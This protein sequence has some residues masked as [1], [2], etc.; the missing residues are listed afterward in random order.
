MKLSLSFLSAA[1]LICLV[2]CAGVDFEMAKAGDP[3]RVLTGTVSWVAEDP[4]PPDAVLRIRIVDTTK[5]EL[6]A[7]VKEEEIR[8]LGMSPT[9]FR[10]EYRAEDALLRRG[11]NVEARIAFAGKIRYYNADSYNITI[12]SYSRPL[13]LHVNRTR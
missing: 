2:G 8:G 5:P 4:L 6:P 10:I 13:Q 1:L 11:L 9:T 3:E 7:V 12:N